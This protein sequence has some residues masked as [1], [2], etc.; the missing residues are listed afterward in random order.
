[1]PLRTPA[2][3]RIEEW[4]R[5]SPGSAAFEHDIDMLGDVVHDGAGVS[6]IVPFSSTT[7][8]RSG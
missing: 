6:F 3:T 2:D 8:V 4:L 7:G 5:S 1:M